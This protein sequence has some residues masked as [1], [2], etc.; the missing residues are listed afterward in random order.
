MVGGARLAPPL[1]EPGMSCHDNRR[2]LGGSREWGCGGVGSPGAVQIGNRT[3][4]WL[5]HRPCLPSVFLDIF[6]AHPRPVLNGAAPWPGS[7][8]PV[9]S[10]PLPQPPRCPPQLLAPHT[11]QM[12]TFTAPTSGLPRIATSYLHP[13]RPVLPAITSP[14]RPRPPC[15]PASCRIPTC[16]RSRPV[17]NPWTPPPVPLDPTLTHTDADQ[18]IHD[19]GEGLHILS[20]GHGPTLPA[21][22]RV[23]DPGRQR[24]RTPG[25]M[26][27]PGGGVGRG[28]GKISLRML[29]GQASASA[30]RGGRW[31]VVSPR[32]SQEAAG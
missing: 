18:R 21:R 7:P 12:D 16:S 6:Q 1:G 28:G 10:G 3:L 31:E 11:P 27:E 4:G 29:R 2:R 20:L 24:L 17:P 30:S 14:L 22:P 5:L 32:G 19:G 26:Q 8:A 13:T 9:H 25:L 15:I 23:P